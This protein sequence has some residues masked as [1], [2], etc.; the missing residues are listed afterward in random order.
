MATRKS[1][2]LALDV[3]DPPTS[4]RGLPELATL[5]VAAGLDLPPV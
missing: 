4:L 1:S 3:M 2:G 5:P